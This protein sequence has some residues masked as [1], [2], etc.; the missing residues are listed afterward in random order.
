[1]TSVQGEHTFHMSHKEDT[2]SVIHEVCMKPLSKSCFNILL[3]HM[4]ALPLV[5]PINE[6]EVL[7]LE[8]KFVNGY[9]EGIRAMYVSMYNN[10][11]HDLDVFN[12]IF[13][14][15]SSIWREANEDFE[16]MLFVRA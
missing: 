9:Q 2:N 8:N 11:D 10:V 14:S 15:W 3:C 7:R 16:D 5:R 12:D 4:Q 1:M 13:A 6:V